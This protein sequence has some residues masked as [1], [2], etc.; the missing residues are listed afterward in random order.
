MPV[1]APRLAF[2]ILLLAW[3]T[4]LCARIT[5]ISVGPVLPLIQAD[6]RL[7]YAQAGLLFSIP[8]LMMGLVSIPSG[9]IIA[10]LGTKWVLVMSLT[11]LCGGG[12]LRSVANGPATLFVFTALMGTGIGLLQPALPRLV[13]DWFSARNG[14]L[15]GIYSTGF[16]LG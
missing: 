5:T 14:L 4:A 11:L 10:R 7:S 1:A 2:L 6:L 16:L 12:A 8:V 13:K 9:L 3:L 15:T